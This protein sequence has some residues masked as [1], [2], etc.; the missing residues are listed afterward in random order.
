MEN[1]D[2][3]RRYIR[4]EQVTDY[5]LVKVIPALVPMSRSKQ[6]DLS[7][8]WISLE[9]VGQTV[10]ARVC[11]FGRTCYEV[12]LTEMPF[13]TL[14]PIGSAHLYDPDARAVRA[15]DPPTRWADVG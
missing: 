13:R 12:L 6:A 3:I 4:E 9:R 2:R 11:F 5:G 14:F 8:H 1:F 7:A 10:F 15:I